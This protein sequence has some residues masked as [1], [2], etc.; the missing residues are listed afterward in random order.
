MKNLSK[1]ASILENPQFTEKYRPYLRGLTT[2]QVRGHMISVDVAAETMFL[3]GYEGQPIELL[4]D[5]HGSNTGFAAE[6]YV[7]ASAAACGEIVYDQDITAVHAETKSVYSGNASI[8]NIPTEGKSW[9]LADY[10]VIIA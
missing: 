4:I 8:E 9:S 6:G 1:T 3:L 10:N 2:E 5:H 7:D